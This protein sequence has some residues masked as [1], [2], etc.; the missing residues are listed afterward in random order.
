MGQFPLIPP[1]YY[2]FSINLSGNAA[3]LVAFL[4]RDPSPIW[5]TVSSMVGALDL[6]SRGTG[7]IPDQGHCVMFFCK[8]LS[9]H[10]ASLPAGV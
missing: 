7:S 8:T 10:S 4:T 3:D 9:S 1:D 6:R 5:N 2:K